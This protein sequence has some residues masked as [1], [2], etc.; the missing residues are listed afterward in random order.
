M[1][2]RNPFTALTLSAVASA[3]LPLAALAL[4]ACLGAES[5]PDDAAETETV[6]EAPEALVATTSVKITRA[7]GVT[8]RMDG[9]QIWAGLGNTVN[10]VV[11]PVGVAAHSVI[12]GQTV[13]VESGGSYFTANHAGNQIF[14]NSGGKVFLNGGA[15]QTVFAAAGATVDCTG[16]GAGSVIHRP[17]GTTLINCAPALGFNPQMIVDIKGTSFVRVAANAAANLIYPTP[18]MTHT[19]SGSVITAVN[20]TTGSYS[21]P[22]WVVDGLINKALPDPPPMFTSTNAAGFTFNVPP[23][24][25]LYRWVSLYVTDPFGL[26]LEGKH[27]F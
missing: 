13:L 1:S 14:V 4:P 6:A 16:T 26:E 5:A 11:V 27:S 2:P 21:N 20:K 12:S 15:G 18:A 24:A 22:H 9:P 10:Q 23:A 7:D 19:L 25:Y 8:V 3:L 17:A